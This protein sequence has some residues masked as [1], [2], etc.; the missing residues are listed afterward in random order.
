MFLFFQTFE[1]LN[2]R[3]IYS[4][5]FYKK[6]HNSTNWL[7]ISLIVMHVASIFLIPLVPVVGVIVKI[8]PFYHVLKLTQ[9]SLI[10]NDIVCIATIM[11]T[12][13]RIF[14]C[15]VSVFEFLR[16]ITQ[17]VFLALCVSYTTITC[18]REL[19]SNCLRSENSTLRLYVILSVVFKS[20]EYFI[21]NILVMLLACSHIIM[22]ASWWAILNCWNKLSILVSTILVSYNDSGCDAA[23]T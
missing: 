19:N 9:L 12:L 18:L 3:N 6:K 4:T 20:G 22:I 8:D 23:S 5:D 15:A 1:I 13:L 14:L 2:I 17:L 10:Q 16:F 11:T 7:G 21:R